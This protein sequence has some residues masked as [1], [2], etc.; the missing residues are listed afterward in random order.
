MFLLFTFFFFNYNQRRKGRDAPG[1]AEG[2][3]QSWRDCQVKIGAEIVLEIIPNPPTPKKGH[4]YCSLMWKRMKDIS[5][6]S[7]AIQP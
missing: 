4:A 7:T 1:W 5:F 6:F 2:D 3:G